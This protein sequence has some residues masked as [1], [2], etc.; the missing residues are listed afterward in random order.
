MLL[1]MSENNICIK[2][3][4]AGVNDSAS[5]AV[6]HA[7]N[8]N[9]PEKN[10]G[11]KVDAILEIRFGGETGSTCIRMCP[12]CLRDLLSAGKDALVNLPQKTAYI[13]VSDPCAPSRLYVAGGAVRELPDGRIEV[14]VKETAALS[15]SYIF[16]AEKA[17]E[18]VFESETEAQEYLEKLLSRPLS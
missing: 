5:C 15:T 17:A 1:K 16:P 12:A 3:L 2:P 6:C 14:R 11:K 7:R 10:S 4:L 8:Y 18:E 9:V 13:V